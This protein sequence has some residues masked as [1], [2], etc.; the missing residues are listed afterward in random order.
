[1]RS[2]IA[3]ENRVMTAVSSTASNAGA[4]HPQEWKMSMRAG[5]RTMASATLHRGAPPHAAIAA[6]TGYSSTIESR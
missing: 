2:A 4:G 5:G 3:M 1:M 6:G